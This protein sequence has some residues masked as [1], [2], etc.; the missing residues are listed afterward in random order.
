MEDAD[1][2]L[3]DKGSK[4]RNRQ[5]DLDN[6]A[7]D[8]ASKTKNRTVREKTKLSYAEQKEYDNIESEIE[9]LESRCNELEKEIALSSTDYTRLMQLQSEKEELETT[10]EKKMERYIEL[11]EMVDSFAKK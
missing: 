10:I 11:Q 3:Q 8:K 4:S 7:S 9:E 1:K 2:G 6:D 5:S